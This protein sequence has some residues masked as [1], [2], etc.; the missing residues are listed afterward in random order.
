VKGRAA[1]TLVE[2]LVGLVVTGMVAALAYAA[3][4]AGL[5]TQ[6]QLERHREGE[7]NDAVVRAIL[8]DALRH[9]VGGVRGGQ[10][11]FAIADRVANDGSAADSLHL[12][13]RGVQAPLGAR[14]AW[15]VDAWREGDALLVEAHPIAY[16]VPLSGEASAPLA[17]VRARLDGVRGFDVRLLGRGPV[18]AWRADWVENDVAPD[19]VALTFLH[20][21]RAGSRLLVRRGLE[22]AP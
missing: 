13:T 21:E 10:A 12:T 15:T 20:T 16:Q 22:R 17:P 14:A 3:S 5:A 18:A 11:V 7:G 4:S 9:Q 1:F 2:V 6:A 19:A 8:T